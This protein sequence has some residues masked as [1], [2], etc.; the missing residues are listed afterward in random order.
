M[1]GTVEMRT[2][3]DSFELLMNRWLLYQDL[4]CRMWARTGF[5]QPGGAFGFRDQLQDALALSL[6]RPDIARA[7]LL[8]AAGRQFLEGDVQHW[9]HEPS[10]R[11]TRT[12]CSDDL[13]WLP[14]A[15]AHYADVT[16][17]AGVLDETAPFLEAP[18]L[19]PGELESYQLPRVSSETA[20]LFDHCVRAI[21]KGI[22]S[23]PQGLPLMGSG[24]WN[25]GMNRVGHQGRGESTWL[26]WF[27]QVV[28]TQ[29]APLCESR[30]DR[31]RSDRY[32]QEASRLAASLERAWDGEWYRRGSFDDGTPLGSAQNE[33]CKIDSIAQSWAVISGAAPAARADRAMDSVR[34][35]LVRRGAQVVLLLTPPFDR[36]LPD[37]GYIKGYAPGIRENGGQYTHAALWTVWPWPGWAAATSGRA[38]PHDQNPPTTRAG[39]VQLQGRAPWWPPTCRAPR[40]RDEGWTWYGP[41]GWMYRVGLEAILGMKV[42]G[43]RWRSIAHPDRLAGLPARGDSGARDTKSWWRIP[44]GAA[45]ASRRPSGTRRREPNPDHRRRTD[46]RVRVVIARRIARPTARCPRQGVS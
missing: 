16:G 19:G 39:R 15:A 44:K 46:G 40:T 14:Y 11:G 2:P 34:T 24:D 35:H 42:H 26:G 13:L 45:G 10:G 33:E 8:R 22:T 18:V 23:G 9:W 6:A 32:R 20:T 29:F 5:Y 30:G 27:L 41:A 28:L 25:D 21:D 7:H 3:D 31:A 12:R 36:S 43:E 17:D 38:V 1:L 4:A 37:P